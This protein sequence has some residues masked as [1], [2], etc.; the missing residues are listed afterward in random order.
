MSNLIEVELA[1]AR[2]TAELYGNDFL[3][4]LIDMALLQA[5][6]STALGGNLATNTGDDLPDP[7]WEGQCR[8]RFG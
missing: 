6:E 1:R 7:G 8:R 3:L 2:K 4:Y 5:K